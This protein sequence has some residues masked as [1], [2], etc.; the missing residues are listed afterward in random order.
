MP[1][2][3]YPRPE[4]TEAAPWLGGLSPKQFMA[5][6]WQKKPLLVRNAFPDF[7][8][9]VSIDEVLSLCTQDT[10]QSRLIQSEPKGQSHR[11]ANWSLA[12]GPFKK[13]DL[14]KI[15][16]SN[17]TVLVQQ[18]NTVLPAADRFLD[19]F[20]F[21]P[22][23]RLDDLMIS[24]AGPGGGIGAHTDSYDVFLIQAQGQR[25]WEIAEHFTPTLI[26]DLPLKILKKFRAEHEWQLN[27]GD[28]LYLPPQVAHRGT[29]VG[30]ACMTWS[31]GF[32]AP[33]R[34]ALA[35]QAWVQHLDQL[36]ESDWRDPWL[37][38]SDQP[39][40]IPEQLLATLTRQV[41]Q[42][43]PNRKALRSAI[44]RALSEPAPS[45][46]FE[47]PR[48]APT[49][50]GFLSAAKRHGIALS[51]ASR[52]LYVDQAF[53]INGEAVST[54]LT[55]SAGTA[56]RDLANH[57]RLSAAHVKRVIQNPSLADCLLQMARAG[58]IVYH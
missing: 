34:V 50:R 10:L 23:A 32:R 11:A 41:L 8:P 38:A 40:E 54:P 29:A 16:D 22:E 55:V 30:A 33:G 37:K 56:L 47:P 14:P 1:N 53:Y 39:G 6:Y 20:R 28:L 52:L 49:L 48:P 24:V 43:L 27:P 31:I 7:E 4:P 36:E 25:R 21:I 58:W 26:D 42:T 3:F 57:R 2:R 17:W 5:R 13:R 46:V 35:D 51:P 18:V 45:A 12:H 15:S 44:A 9:A 19:A